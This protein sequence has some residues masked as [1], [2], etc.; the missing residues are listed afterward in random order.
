MFKPIQAIACVASITLP[1]AGLSHEAPAPEHSRIV[2]IPAYES[3]YG[4]PGGNA[5][6]LAAQAFL[7]AFDASERKVFMFPFNSQERARWSNLP[8]GIFTRSGLSISEMSPRQRDS[9]FTLLASSLSPAGYGRL[10]DVLAA[11]T[12]L[13]STSSAE[14]YGWF[15]ENYWISF[16]GTPSAKEPWGLQFGGHHLALNITVRKGRVYTMSPSFLGTEPAVFTLNG[17][18]YEAIADMHRAGYATFQLLSGT[19]QVQ[20][21]TGRVPRDVVTGPG[22]DG[23]VPDTIGISAREMT[24][25]QRQSLLEAIR[26]WVEIQPDENARFRMTRIEADLDQ[27]YFAWR[28]TAEVNTPVYLRIQGPSLIIEL[29]SS[30]GNFSR[31]ASG[32]GHYH[33]IYRNPNTE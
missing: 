15:P 7:S 9:L 10:N 20:A 29:V 24:P 8:S 18:N 33:T 22:R 12:F 27:T 13:S 25:D 1:T 32:F 2:P 3:P 14:Q 31:N 11:E 30:G 17:V 26:L 6:T 16:Y 21:D 19:Q 4:D 23:H 28:G 5:A